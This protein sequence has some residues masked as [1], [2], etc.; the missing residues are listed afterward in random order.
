MKNRVITNATPA[1]EL[2][3]SV[4]AGKVITIQVAPE[5]K[6]PNVI[7]DADGEG[8]CL[9]VMQ[10][11]DRQAMETLV[12]NFEKKREEAEGKGQKYAVLVDADHSSETST[13]TQAMGWVTKLY[14][15]DEKG[16]MAEIEP[17]SL[18]AE[19]IN[20]KIYRFV[21][22]AWTLDDDC[23]PETLISI[24]LTNRPNL[25]VNAI[26]NSE[27]VGQVKAGDPNE[28][29]TRATD[30]DASHIDSTSNEL[31]DK[32]TDLSTTAVTTHDGVQGKNKM[33]INTIK[34]MFGLTAES[35]D[36]ELKAVLEQIKSKAESMEGVRNALSCQN[37]DT[38]A[39]VV[40]TVAELVDMARNGQAA[41]D[42]LATIKEAQTNAEAEDFVKENSDVIP[43]ESAEQI[44]EQYKKDPEAAQAVV[45]N[46][47]KVYERA[48]L[49]S[50]RAPK[51]DEPKHVVVNAK[52][53]KKPVALNDALS[54][55]NG[56]PRKENEIIA[57]MCVSK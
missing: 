7:D 40:K 21:S 48:I 6:Y 43:E 51:A 13:N 8:N 50:A 10:V 30:D 2:P 23:R 33:D 11:L 55:C 4:E 31:A 1:V 49:N 56:D 42:E 54:A 17:T 22:G 57:K 32:T 34:E 35:T 37:D 5:G 38:D 36:D 26:I 44:K 41:I 9:R 52:T 45:A 12:E 14:V 3:Q 47:R 53:A 39:D 24:G 16:L 15:D 18:G 46:F 27:I 25:P 20:D 29:V 19:K 28:V